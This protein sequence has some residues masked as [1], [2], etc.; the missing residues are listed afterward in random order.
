MK[1]I[2]I[3]ALLFCTAALVVSC[4][5]GGDDPD[6]VGPQEEET[7]SKTLSFVL[8]SDAPGKTAWTAGDKIVVHGEYAADQ[9]T[10]TLSAGDISSDGKT[11]TLLVEGLKPYV[12]ED[13]GSSLYAAWPAEAVDNLRHCFF[14]SKFNGTNRPL[15]AACNDGD[16]FRFQP[17]GSI[18]SFTAEGMDEYELSGNKKEAVGYEFLQVK[19]TD[20]EQN[21]AQYKGN[22][23]LTVSGP[24][25]GTT[26]VYL[27]EGT[28]FPHGLTLKFKK[29]GKAVKILKITDAQELVRGQVTDL[30]D[31]TDEL[32][33]YDDPFSDDILD[34][35]KDG[36]A[37]CYIVTA[38]GVYKFKAVKGNNTASY[39]EDVDSAVILWET[40]NNAE[41]VT[42][43]SVV[44]SVSYAEDYMIFHTPET[45][46]PGN[47]VLA[48]LDEAGNALWS[49]HIWV[50]QTAITTSSYGD[51]FGAEAMDRN[52]G[53]LLPATAGTDPL[54]PET[55]GLSYQW[56]HKDP[57][58][59]PQA[60]KSSKPATVAG[61]VAEVAPGQISLEESIANPTLLGHMNNLGWLKPADN[62]LWS[63]DDKAMYD[64]CPA[65]YR[66]PK[67]DGSKPFWGSDLTKAEGW[68][69]NTAAGWF[70]IGN[71]A[72]VFPLAGYR[73]DYDV[74]GFTH[75]YDRC[76][77]WTAYA[78][79]D[80][81]AYG[82]D[83]RYGSSAKLKESP[84]AR[85]GYVRCVK[86]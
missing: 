59:G 23:L 56:G 76:L 1:R 44:T 25:D 72:A 46:R 52:L 37:N 85:A 11:A 54:A 41:E 32:D 75:V 67:R 14:Y 84:K 45:L 64:P 60:Y 71:P 81:V 36:N 21:Y 17:V 16:S 83:V 79:S 26:F 66:V 73:D 55:F 58:P 31:I 5:K 33:D 86:E 24:V 77:Y 43:H 34:I 65:G 20:K 74:G 19:V 38:P 9:V 47:A 2:H 69:G 62:T 82:S 8:P 7:V 51:I 3:F 78:S 70:T 28:E 61:Q 29:A 22:A 13:Y 35:D 6:P 15:L 42:E 80:G 53:A 18:L 49:W 68:N 40:W 57:F 63:N 27:P 48:A 30:G 50:P 12:R 39:V 4:R 10:V